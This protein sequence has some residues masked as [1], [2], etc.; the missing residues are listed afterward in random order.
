M[1]QKREPV[2][3]CI[4]NEYDFDLEKIA[5]FERQSPWVSLFSLIRINSNQNQNR[6]IFFYNK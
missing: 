1:F 2:T 6:L 5:N 4:S 3:E